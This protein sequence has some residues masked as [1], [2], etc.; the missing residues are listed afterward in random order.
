VVFI[1]DGVYTVWGRHGIVEGGPLLNIQETIEMTSDSGIIEYYTLIPSMK[2][3]GVVPS[4]SIKGVFPIN[5]GELARLILAPPPG[6]D[7]DLQRVFLI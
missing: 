2:L 4:G 5:A 3:R 7:S 6:T 1:E